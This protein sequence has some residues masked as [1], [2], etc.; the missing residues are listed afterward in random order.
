MCGIAGAYVSLIK[1][2]T[3]DAHELVTAIVNSQYTRGPDNQAVESFTGKQVTAIFGH[4]R[5]SII[6]L[7]AS[8]NQ[9]MWDET[10]RYCLVFNG[11]I[12]NYLELRAELV[13]K[14]IIFKTASDAEVLMQA[15]I[16]WGE[17]AVERFNGMFA[18]AIFD[19][20]TEN[21]WLF[22]D[23]FG[24]KPLYYYVAD[25]A[26]YFASTGKV[27]AATLG[28]KPNLSYLA[29]GLRFG[30]YDDATSISQYENLKEL[31][32]GH[33]LKVSIDNRSKLITQLVKYYDLEQR[34]NDLVDVLANKNFTELLQELKELFNQA[35]KFRL[36]ADVPIGISLSGGL[37]SATV[38]GFAAKQHPN[39]IGFTLGDPLNQKTEG[40][41]VKELA[42]K[43]GIEVNYIIPK[44]E[45]IEE[46]FLRTLQA[47]DAPFTTL[48]IVAQ[49]LVYKTANAKGIKVLLGGQGGDES[50]LGYR[51]FVMFYYL[52]LLKNQQYFPAIKFLFSMFPMFARE[53]VNINLYWERRKRYTS[54][55]G[56]VSRLKLPVLDNQNFGFAASQ[57][58]RQRQIG[59]I[60]NFSLP[61]LLRYEDRNSMNWSIE[62]RLPFLDYNLVEFA[63]ALPVACKLKNG[64]GKW[65]VRK[66]AEE[67]LPRSI[68][69]ARNKRG[70]DLDTAAWINSG[71]G[72]TIRNIIKQ[73]KPL[74]QE[75]LPQNC[76]IDELFSDVNLI[77]NHT[78]LQEAITL[79]WLGKT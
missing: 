75:L 70:F 33:Y 58:V 59:D 27:I 7:N 45:E 39:I 64:Y 61:T 8:A 77:N 36:R 37:D 74:L 19:T 78:R 44:T 6:D 30:F 60:L 47:Q 56:E 48:S 13:T 65:I 26:L 54:T 32:S 79:V 17:K 31:Q 29:R 41:L 67:F 35:I 34:A 42:K 71:L 14:G 51:K 18:F 22:R 57:G 63:I 72:Q 52:Q 23:R 62:S 10:K 21:L 2:K 5:L 12:Y 15:F 46:T 24:I 4:D 66:M 38:A 3:I 68:S 28:L 20:L 11:E 53:L 43:I 40:P 50:F 69:F 49:N 1:S 73:G 25:D 9:P 16:T 55:Q 76:V